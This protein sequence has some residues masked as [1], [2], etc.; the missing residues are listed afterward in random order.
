MNISQRKLTDDQ[1]REIRGSKI[2]PPIL[3]K[4]YNVAPKTIRSIRDRLL[5][6]EVEDNAEKN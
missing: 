3:A 4:Y 1:V 5:Y 6:K 2:S